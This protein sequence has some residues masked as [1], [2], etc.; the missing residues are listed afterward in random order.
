MSTPVAS[1][2][3][4]RAPW[5]ELPLRGYGGIE[6]V[7]AGLADALVARGHDVIVIGAGRNGTP[8][9]LRRT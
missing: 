4:G 2:R 1:H 6:A 7:C 9:Q 8:A 3:H 5:F